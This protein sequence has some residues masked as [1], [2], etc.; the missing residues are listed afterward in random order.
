MRKGC[1]ALTFLAAFGAAAGIGL[2]LFANIPRL[3]PVLSGHEQ[4]AEMVEERLNAKLEA[5]WIAPLFYPGL[6]VQIRDLDIKLTDENGDTGD[7]F[8][9]ASVKITVD[10]DKLVNERKAVPKE[11]ILVDPELFLKRRPD[12]TW[13]VAGWAGKLPKPE[14]KEPED[15]SVAEWYAKDT[16]SQVLPKAATGF[17]DLLRLDRVEVKN[18]RLVMKDRKRGKRMLLQDVDMREINL[19]VL[20]AAADSPASFEFSAPFPQT[21]HG[22][23]R[24]QLFSLRGALSSPSPY[25]LAVEHA[26][27]G[28]STI[29]FHEISGWMEAKPEF[30]FDANLDANA[31]FPDIRR[32]ALWGPVA[33]SK[34][35]PAMRGSGG[36]RVIARV[37]GPEPSR[38]AKVHYRG[39]IE[40][41]GLT[42]DAG[43]VVAPL[44]NVHAA[45]YL[46][47]GTARMPETAIKIADTTL[48]GSGFIKESKNPRFTMNARADYVDFDKFFRPRR[49][50]LKAGKPMLP[51]RTMWGGDAYI[52]LGVYNKIRIE[53]VSGHWDVTNKRFLTFPRLTMKA[54]RGTYTESGRSWVDFNHPTDVNFRCDGTIDGMD[55]TEFVDQLLDTTIFLH[56]TADAKGYITGRFVEGEFVTR[57][58]SGDLDIS[59]KDGFFEE[60]NLAGKFLDLFGIEPPAAIRDQRYHRM[61]ANVRFDRGVAY[62]TDLEV[63][64]PGLGVSANGWIDFDSQHT[65]IKLTLYPRGAFAD[66]VRKTPVLGLAGRTATTLRV[67]A[68]GH[69]DYLKFTTWM[70][71]NEEAPPSP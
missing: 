70:P 19:R 14:P 43:R 12:G 27:G 18:M 36:G 63:D 30:R 49:E 3:F 67:R 71:A 34:T 47:D 9:A 24:G 40:I 29:V 50:P 32:A 10:F 59:L 16:L 21:N 35:M 51:M 54:M 68:H 25:K 39:R 66:V 2:L 7:F 26:R 17:N 6:G 13:S 41:N 23:N 45:I 38:L 15:L 46:E 11:V 56:G 57:S 65:D 42:Y 4:L 22:K 52:G 61:S 44:E 69:W 1:L 62:L 37:W 20:G 33:H 48:T 8:R 64:A 60:F 31:A 53:D 5:G 58:L 28:W 55:M